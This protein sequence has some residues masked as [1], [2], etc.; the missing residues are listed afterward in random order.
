MSKHGTKAVSIICAVVAIILLC[1]A[2]VYK[3][4]FNIEENAYIYVDKDDNIDSLR[5]KVNTAGNPQLEFSFDIFTAVLSL[6]ENMRTGKFEI[7]PDLSMFSLLRNIRNHYQVPVKFV[8]GSG[9]RTNED[10]AGKLSRNIMLDSAAIVSLL[11]DEGKLEKYGY[12]VNTIPALFIPNTYEVWWDM[13][14]ESLMERMIKENNSFWNEERTA[15]LKEV[16]EYSGMQ[17]TKEN[18]ITMAS[19]VDSETA[20]NGEKPNIAALYL[21]RL[22]I[23][24]PLQSDPTVKYALKEFGLRRILHEHLQVES[25]YNTYKNQGLPPGPICIPSISSIDAVLNHAHNDYIYMCAKEDFSG[26]HNF[27]VSYNEHL[28]NAKRYTNALNKRNIH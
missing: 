8:V 17:F 4:G 16:S 25:P 1:G 14:I 3:S 15:K 5:T 20:N 27:A 21:N 18:L 9:I 26:T 19:I 7:S 22:R 28:Q 11:N 10:L 6:N 23:H 2:A 13:S 12:N 24:M